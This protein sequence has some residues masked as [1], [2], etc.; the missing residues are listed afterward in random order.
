MAIAA[1]DHR[2][3][4][5]AARGAL[6]IAALLLF[7]TGTWFAASWIDAEQ[8]DSTCGAAIHPQVWLDDSAPNSCQGVMAIR[9][10]IAAATIAAGGVLLYIAIRR[11]VTPALAV[12]VLTIAAVASAIILVINE[13]VRSD[14]AL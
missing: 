14:G 4:G 11:R 5:V 8:Y 10:T 6:A 1:G 7:G 2:T 12:T 13:I 3:S 9:A